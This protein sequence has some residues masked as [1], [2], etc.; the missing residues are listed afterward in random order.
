MLC[1]ISKRYYA[2]QAWLGDV[3]S[4]YV[5]FLLAAWLRLL[6]LGLLFASCFL[7]VLQSPGATSKQLRLQLL[8]HA[9]LFIS[10]TALHSTA[11][12]SNCDPNFQYV[13]EAQEVR[14]H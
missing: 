8:A 10:S 11:L 6:L 9:R 7:S 1:I 12:K 3:L 13:R 4:E 14:L 2:H 5:R